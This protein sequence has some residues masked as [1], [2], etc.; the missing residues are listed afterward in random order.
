FLSFPC[1]LCV[2]L[3]LNPSVHSKHHSAARAVFRNVF[4]TVTTLFAGTS[5][6]AARP[7]LTFPTKTAPLSTTRFAA[8]TSPNKHPVDLRTIVPELG[9][10][11]ISSPPISAPPTRSSSGQRNWLP[12]G[13]ISRPVLK[14][15]LILA[16]E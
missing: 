4:A 10:L 6:R 13:M 11:A 7:I 1:V 5:S 8:C 12:T 3:R 15:P 2:L 9:R 16:V 14:V